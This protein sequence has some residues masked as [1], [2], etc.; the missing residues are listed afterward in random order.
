MGVRV[1]ENGGIHAK[2]CTIGLDTLRE[3]NTAAYIVA[4]MRIR[5]GDWVDC[6]SSVRDTIDPAAAYR[7]PKN[8]IPRI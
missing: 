6:K 2:N 1:V 8:S 7:L 5:M 3:P 4:I